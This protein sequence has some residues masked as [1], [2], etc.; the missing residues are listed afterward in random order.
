[1]GQ[2]CP[3]G[4][5]PIYSVDTEEEAKALMA[6]VPMGLNGEHYANE[7]IGD[8]GQPLEGAE[9]VDGFIRFGLKLEKIHA[10]ILKNKKRRG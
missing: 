2:V 6:F 5:L 1:M 7:L 10:F 3:E 4:F 9:R 8:D